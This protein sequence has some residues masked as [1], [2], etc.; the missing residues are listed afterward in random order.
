[1]KRAK[2]LTNFD[3]ISSYD[4]GS[5]KIFVCGTERDQNPQI[6]YPFS[7][8]EYDEELTVCGGCFKI[9]NPKNIYH[10]CWICETAYCDNCWYSEMNSLENWN[11]IANGAS[12]EDNIN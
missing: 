3:K 9:L 8:L 4:Y 12:S 2:S 10:L 11:D 7:D 5:I 6:H 1:M